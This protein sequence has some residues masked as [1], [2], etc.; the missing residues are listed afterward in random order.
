MRRFALGSLLALAVRMLLATA[1][2]AQS[3]GGSPPPDHDRTEGPP[4]TFETLAARMEQEERDGFSGSILV[5]HGDGIVLSR[6]YGFADREAKIRATPETIYGIG[7]ALMPIEI[8]RRPRSQ[9][10][11]RTA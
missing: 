4:L 5:A 11:L 9:F 8:A 7:P 2:H 1:A 6:G 10:R 3:G